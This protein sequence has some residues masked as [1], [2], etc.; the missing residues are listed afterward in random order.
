[1]KCA[2]CGN[3]FTVGV[4]CP[5]CGF[6]NEQIKQTIPESLNQENQQPTVSNEEKSSNF[7]GKNVDVQDVQKKGKGLAVVSLICG[8]ISILTIGVLIV[9]EVLGIVFALVSK[10]GG[11]MQG[12]AKAGFIC[13]IVS[14][15]ILIAIVV[16]L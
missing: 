9:P 6:K 1:M 8:I 15:V 14:I 4:F 11:E 2:K 3:E 12:T 10:K 16:L 7:D 13:S 5:E